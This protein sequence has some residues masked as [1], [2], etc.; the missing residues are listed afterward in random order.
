M[1]EDDAHGLWRVHHTFLRV[2]LEF[3]RHASSPLLSFSLALFVLQ[4]L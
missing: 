4:P 3:G 2:A 1:I